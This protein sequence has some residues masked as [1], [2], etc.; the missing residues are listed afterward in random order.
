[1]NKENLKKAVAI[2]KKIELLKTWGNDPKVEVKISSHERGT[3]ILFH[4]KKEREFEDNNILQ[5][6]EVIEQI[7]TA[8]MKVEIEKA[9]LE[10]E[11][12]LE[13]L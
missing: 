9:I 11:C 7:A 1:M 2:N 6:L 10:L 12:K 5:Q 3:F 8:T 4:A 13:A